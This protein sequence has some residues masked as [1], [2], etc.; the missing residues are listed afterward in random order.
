MTELDR[1]IRNLYLSDSPISF[2]SYVR[3]STDLVKKSDRI[4]MLPGRSWVKT[5][6]SIERITIVNAGTRERPYGE[7]R[8]EYADIPDRDRTATTV[9]DTDDRILWNSTG[10]FQL[11]VRTGRYE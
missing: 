3:I 5:Y 10:R 1:R 4:D 7:R 8:T 11:I 2:Q 9:H 6:R